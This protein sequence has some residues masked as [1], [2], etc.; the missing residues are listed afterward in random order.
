[1]AS[2]SSSCYDLLS[3]SPEYTNF[4][5]TV[6]QRKVAHLYCVRSVSKMIVLQFDWL[7]DVLM[8]VCGCIIDSIMIL[9]QHIMLLH[10]DVHSSQGPLFRSTPLFCVQNR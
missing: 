9:W 1:M 7:F 5:S 2:V 3:Q 6:P 10:L 8:S 4:R